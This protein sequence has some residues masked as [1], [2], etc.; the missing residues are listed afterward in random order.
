MADNL[1]EPKSR[2]ESYLAKAAGM[3]V[4]IPEAPESRLEQYLEAI[5]ESGGGGGGDINVVQTTGASATDVM[6]QKAVTDVLFNN[7]SPQK[8]QIGTG[9]DSSST[10]N[11][12]S[13]AIGSSKATNINTIAIG[14]NASSLTSDAICLGRDSTSST[15][16]HNSVAIGRAS[17]ATG[18]SAVAIGARATATQKGQFDISTG[19]LAWGYNN[20]NYRLLTGL[21][22]PQNAHDAA[23]KGYVDTKTGGFTLLGISQTDYDNMQTKDPNTLYIITGA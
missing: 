16:S 6:S 4:T 3:D 11:G 2:K 23:T 9:A 22:D 1:P 17:S 5:A 8:I 10:G 21:Y 20:S 12:S 19:T 15:L 18:E 7:N 13:I 14:T